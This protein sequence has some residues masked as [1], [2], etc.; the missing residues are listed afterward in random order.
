MKTLDDYN[1]PKILKDLDLV[2]LGILISMAVGIF[3]AGISYGALQST[4]TT[5]TL[6]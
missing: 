1:N 2:N 3:F 5:P 4:T 6:N